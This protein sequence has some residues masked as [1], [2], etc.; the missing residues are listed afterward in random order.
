MTDERGL[1]NENGPEGLRA[2]LRGL[3]AGALDV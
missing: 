3:C 1:R 2:V